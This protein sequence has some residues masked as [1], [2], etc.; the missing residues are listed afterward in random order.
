M[1]KILATEASLS[2]TSLQAALE[3]LGASKATLVV[4]REDADLAM[5]LAKN[6]SLV[7]G[8]FVMVDYSRP[9]PARDAWYVENNPRRVWGSKA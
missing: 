1:E 6:L 9:L 7:G 3:Q 5:E 4:T 8:P 2:F